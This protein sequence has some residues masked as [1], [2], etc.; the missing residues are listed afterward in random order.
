M[1]AC[2]LVYLLLLDGAAEV[3]HR[4]VELLKSAEHSAVVAEVEALSGYLP[5]VAP[6]L[7][8]PLVEMCLPALR[9]LSFEQY[10]RFSDTAERLAQA[11]AR[12]SL[13]EFTLKTLLQRHLAAHFARPGRP[14]AQI[15]GLRGVAQECSQVLSLLAR[16]GQADEPQAQKAFARGARIVRGPNVDVDFI[17]AQECSLEA[18]GQALERLALA[19]PLIK[20][21]LL[22][23]CLEC[24]AHDGTVEVEEVELFRAVAD[25]LGCPVP[26]WVGAGRDG[27]GGCGAGGEESR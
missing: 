8:L 23:A 14:V 27:P 3:R 15:Y 6:R 1:G 5:S 4:Q 13:F 18:M 21:K 12:L 22:A 16:V 17:P 24:V 25:A 2:A 11:D 7:R 9:R 20:K 10:R 26:P 19:S